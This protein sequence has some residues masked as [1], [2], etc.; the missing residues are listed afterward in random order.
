MM[1]LLPELPRHVVDLGAG[2]G[3]MDFVLKSLDPRI[4]FTGYEL[5]KER[6]QEGN[7]ISTGSYG[8]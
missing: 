5:V 1:T 3:R 7:K 8:R 2:Y 4:E 6:V